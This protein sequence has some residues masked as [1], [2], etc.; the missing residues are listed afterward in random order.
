MYTDE[1]HNIGFVFNHSFKLRGL[2]VDGQFVSLESL[3]HT[4]NSEG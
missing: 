4:Q 3:N 2:I 1:T